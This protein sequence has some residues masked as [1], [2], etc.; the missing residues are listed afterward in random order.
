[1]QR[2]DLATPAPAGPTSIVS[3]LRVSIRLGFCIFG[4]FVCSSIGIVPSSAQDVADAARQ[5]RARKEAEHKKPKHVYTE[6]DLK[7]AQ[8]LTPEDRAEL[9]AKRNEQLSVDTDKTEEA[10]DNLPLGTHVSASGM[11]PENFLTPLP[12]DAPLGDVARYYRRWKISQAL[13]REQQFPLAIPK[14]PVLASPKPMEPFRAPIP[15]PAPVPPRFDP[16]QR[17]MQPTRPSPALLNPAPPEFV[18]FQPPVKRSP[19]ARPKFFTAEPPRVS[20]SR[21]APPSLATQWPSKP[22]KPLALGKASRP[23]VTATPSKPLAKVNPPAITAPLDPRKPLASATPIAPVQPLKPFAAG[24]PS[25][26]VAPSKSAK[27]LA[28]VNPPA[29]ASALDPTRPLASGTSVTPAEPSKPFVFGNPSKPVD[30]SKSAKS[31]AH[32]NPPALVAPPRP[33]EPLAS[34]TP[35]APV[36]PAMPP[37]STTPMASVNRLVVTAKHGD[38][39]WKLAEENLG[40]G[41]RWHELLAANPSIHDANHIEAGSQ[42]FLPAAVS[43]GRTVATMIVQKGDSLSKIARAIFGHGS[44]WSC[45]VRANPSIRDAN[46]IYAGQTLS[47]PANCKR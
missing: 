6:E 40:Q 43:S 47:L 15:N 24:N 5:E 33:A 39:L 30:P 13:R 46:L 1:M 3:R 10:L 35:S 17:L 2:T 19:F 26:P 4:I 36:A 44:A 42:I 20:S 32:V 22:T 37:K 38:S 41:L 28:H 25:K 7:R 14:A 11:A 34:A 9:E 18:P 8:I 29:I 12:P 31:P 45:I 21:P 27:S 23:L 16:T